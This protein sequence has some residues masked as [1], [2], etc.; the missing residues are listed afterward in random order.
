MLSAWSEFGACSAACAGTS[1]TPTQTRVRFVVTQPFGTGLPCGALVDTA[2][3][4]TMSCSVCN[5]INCNMGTLLV[6]S[7]SWCRCC[8]Y[9]QP[10]CINNPPNC[11]STVFQ[12]SGCVSSG[13]CAV[14]NATAFT[15]RYC[16]R[17]K[18]PDKNYCDGIVSV[19]CVVSAWS[20]FGACSRS[21]ADVAG[22]VAP[23]GTQTRSRIVTV[24]NQMQG[25]PCP[26]LTE[27]APCNTA[28]CP[29][30]C[31]VSPSVSLLFFAAR[32]D[33][34]GGAAVR[35]VGV[36]DVHALVRRRH[37][38]ADAHGHHAAGGRRRAVPSARA[39]PELR[40]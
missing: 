17:D 6:G 37:A 18:L 35:V 12:R 19:N 3:C 39:A 1:G 20:P 26:A 28:P 7:D 2:A 27:S 34:V 15:T 13:W 14:T 24:L 40:Q 9:A 33:V 25:A 4:N 30:P 8:Y 38:D 11:N 31:E 29:V 36:V 22:G 21:C 23:N 32:S 10:R 16:G 5:C